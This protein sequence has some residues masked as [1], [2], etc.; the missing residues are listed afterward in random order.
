MTLVETGWNKIKVNHQGQFV[1]RFIYNIVKKWSVISLHV[2]ILLTKN[3]DL[4]ELL[5]SMWCPLW[6]KLIFGHM[7]FTEEAGLGPSSEAF[8]SCLSVR[9]I[10]PNTWGMDP[11][12][13]LLGT[14]RPV[15]LDFP[16][17]CSVLL[18]TTLHNSSFSHYQCLC[19]QILLPLWLYWRL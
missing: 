13:A 5:C 10:Y 18:G 9:I 14:L 6:M 4:V 12:A 3:N 17:R 8:E 2:K 19:P 11:K 15:P 1:N 7:P 16:V